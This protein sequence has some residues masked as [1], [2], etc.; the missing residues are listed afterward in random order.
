MIASPPVSA[1]YLSPHR[2]PQY[3]NHYYILLSK[4]IGGLR[5]NDE[6]ISMGFELEAL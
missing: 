5:T 4:Y 2:A 6:Q 1:P 3:N